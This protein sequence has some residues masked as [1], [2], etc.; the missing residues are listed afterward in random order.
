MCMMK[1]LYTCFLVSFISFFSLFSQSDTISPSW[2]T[3]RLIYNKA[4]QSL[5]NN[6]PIEAS[7]LFSTITP[8]DLLLPQFQ[9]DLLIAETISYVQYTRQNPLPPPVRF[10]VSLL[11]MSYAENI[12][13]SAFNLELKLEPQRKKPSYLI[14]FW[15]KIIQNE[16]KEIKKMSSSFILKQPIQ[17]GELQTLLRK[18]LV[19][20]E[21]ALVL[22]LS[23]AL[24]HSLNKEMLKQAQKKV[25]IAVNPFFETVLE[26]QK[27]SFNIY[28]C[29]QLPWESIIPSFIIGLEAAKEA[30][31]QMTFFEKDSQLILSLQIETIISWTE[32]LEK[33]STSIVDEKSNYLF[34]EQ[35]QEML[36][37]DLPSSPDFN[38]EMH[39]W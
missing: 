3:P 38:Q 14:Q 30:H 27:K 24:S 9:R 18:G 5:H 34:D 15:Q 8:S 37:Q 35:I 16:S 6:K 36:L 11:F 29:Q 1:I 25:L 13:E 28:Q 17:E 7:N 23:S 32:T 19:E 39:S 4:L 22:T 31:K 20:A 21:R 2:Q 10:E 26:E 12:L 33:L